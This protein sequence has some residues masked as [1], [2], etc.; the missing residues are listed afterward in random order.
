MAGE[1]IIAIIGP[2]DFTSSGHFIVLS[3]YA[4]GKIRVND[5]N[6]KSRSAQLWDYEIL[7]PQIR[8]LWRCRAANPPAPELS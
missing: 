8:N 2:G 3:A 4:E 5:P 6:S 7:A 1:P